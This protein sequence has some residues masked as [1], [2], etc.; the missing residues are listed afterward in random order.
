MSRAFYPHTL[1]DVA[2]A[3]DGALGLVVADLP[4]GT[5]WVMKR[6]RKSG[7]YTLSHFSDAQR[8]V[9]LERVDVAQ[10]DAALREMAVRIGL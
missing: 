4:D 3:V 9:L 5:I 2:R 10:R 7:G 1:E 6:D 8:S